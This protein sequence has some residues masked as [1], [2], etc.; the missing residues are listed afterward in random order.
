MTKTITLTLSLVGLSLAGCSG[1]DGQ[2][3]S[4]GSQVA[5]GDT[6]SHVGPVAHAEGSGASD[7]L[8][9]PSG[10]PISGSSD[11]VSPQERPGVSA[12]SQRN[13]DRS[14]KPPRDSEREPTAVAPTSEP[15]VKAGPGPAATPTSIPTETCAPEHRALGHC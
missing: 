3:A 14:S 12:P 4:Q 8:A 1:G 5:A 6:G 13:Q 7:P 11:R 2:D 9:S 15:A 10:N